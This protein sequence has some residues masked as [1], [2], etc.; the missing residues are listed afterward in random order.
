MTMHRSRPRPA[1]RTRL[2]ATT[3]AAVGVLF[4]GL[5]AASSALVV[6]GTA[7]KDVTAGLD[8][9]NADNPFIQPPGVLAKQHL[10]NADVLFGRADDD[11]LIG[12]LGSDTL[13]GG[14]GSDILIGG[15]EKSASP[16]SDVLVGDTGEDINIWAPGDGNDAFVGNQGVDTMIFAPFVE[17]AD[18]SLWFSRYAGRQLP[19]VDIEHH[20]RLS[21]TI[22]TV[23]ASEHLGFEHLV[24]FNVDDDPVATVRQKDVEGVFCP[25]PLPGHVAFAS[26]TSA[27]PQFR[28]VWIS[29]V[30]GTIGQILAPVG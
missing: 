27:H 20:A 19:R 2:L 11:L 5:S 12:N 13:L 18:G 23:P 1:S 16:N 21:C 6:P 26:L 10:D 29:N 24:R 14:A 22:V 8:N 4:L 25:S 28:D 30:Q 3:T 17:K 15:P 9:D 7:A